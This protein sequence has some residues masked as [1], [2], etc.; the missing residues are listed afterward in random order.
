MSE[1]TLG[2]VENWFNSK[3]DVKIGK[4]KWDKFGFSH[5]LLSVFEIGLVQEEYSLVVWVIT[6]V[7]VLG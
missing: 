2:I 3:Y 5:V 6:G 1:S 4:D 7:S